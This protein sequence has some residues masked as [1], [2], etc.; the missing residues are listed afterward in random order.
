MGRRAALAGEPAAAA[1][2]GD[3]YIRHGDLPPN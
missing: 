3:I 2:I 1:M